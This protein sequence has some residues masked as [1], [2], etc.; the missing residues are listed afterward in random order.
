MQNGAGGAQ[1]ARFGQR[2]PR[3]VARARAPTC[4][5]EGNAARARAPTCQERAGASRSRPQCAAGA[6]ARTP[7]KGARINLHGANGASRGSARE[8][9]QKRDERR[10]GPTGRQEL[11]FE[12]RAERRGRIR[13][14]RERAARNARRAA[15]RSSDKRQTHGVRVD[16]GTSATTHAERQIYSRRDSNPQ[17]PP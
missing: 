2:A 7:R 3:N 15:A 1:D 14:P 5:K 17:S 11:F 9:K 6:R 16:C 4:Q 10:E 8:G 12:A 13:L